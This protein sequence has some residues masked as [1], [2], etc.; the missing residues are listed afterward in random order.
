M[1]RTEHA[2]PR[3]LA[4][5]RGETTRYQLNADIVR[6]LDLVWPVLREQGVTT[7]H[8]VVVYY[9]GEGGKFTIEAGVEALTDFTD[10]GQ[11]R[12]VSTPPGEVAAVTRYGEY[13]DLG[14]AYAALESWCRDAGRRP[15]GVNWEVYGDWDEDPAKRRTDVYFLLA[16]STSSAAE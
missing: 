1:V 2:S 7:D 8:N 15:A 9:G 16:P 12:H 10:R 13:S 14:S 5:V 4:A 11:V 6:L 3:L